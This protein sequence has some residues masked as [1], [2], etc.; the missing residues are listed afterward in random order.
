MCNDDKH[1]WTSGSFTTMTGIPRGKLCDC[2]AMAWG[3]KSKAEDRIGKLEAER[4][5]LQAIVDKLPKTDDGVTVTQGDMVYYP[6]DGGHNT[7]GSNV[8]YLVPYANAKGI[9][10]IPVR[11]CF[12]TKKAAREAAAKGQ[13]APPIG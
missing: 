9:D 7:Y 5:R 10:W 6:F 1:T 3:G 2:G 11:Q 13:H 4:D 12:S 8:K